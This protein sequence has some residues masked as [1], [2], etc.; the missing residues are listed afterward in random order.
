M[1]D[2]AASSAS[3]PPF[4]RSPGCASR[5][6]LPFCAHLAAV[7]T[8]QTP[9]GPPNSAAGRTLPPS[10]PLSS[11]TATPRTTTFPI[12]LRRH[13]TARPDRDPALRHRRHPRPADDQVA[14]LLSDVVKNDASIGD[15]YVPSATTATTRFA[16]FPLT[17][18]PASDQ[19]HDH[20][21]RTGRAL[22]NKERVEF[23]KGIAGVE[24]GVAAPADSSTTSPSAPRSCKALDLATDHRG[25]AYGA[26]DLGHLFGA[27]S[28]WAPAS[29]WPAN[30]SPAI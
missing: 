7:S 28:R 12:R 27:Q 3:T 19:R 2:F 14:R 20:R 13:L 29:T 15:D 10:P 30:G 16:A 8:P 1:F 18:P 11:F 4:R 9:A 21:R 17:S 24:S 6:C 22:E 26:V 25:T 23:L 5:L